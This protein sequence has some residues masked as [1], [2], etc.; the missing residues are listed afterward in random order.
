L[1]EMGM[2]GVDITDSLLRRWRLTRRRTRLR[3][4]INTDMAPHL[5]IE[6]GERYRVSALSTISL[7]S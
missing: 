3:D 2:I 1:S 6:S 5:L 7:K 4:G